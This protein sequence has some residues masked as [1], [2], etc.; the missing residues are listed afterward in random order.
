MGI[1]SIPILGAAVGVGFAIE[2]LVRGDPVGAGLEAVGSLGS[3]ITAIPATALQEAR[4]LY[5][6]FYG[7]YPEQDTA[8][9]K[10]Q[11]W[12]DLYEAVQDAIREELR[13]KATEKPEIDYSEIATDMMG[14]PIGV[15]PPLPSPPPP[16]QPVQRPSAPATEV[17]PTDK[18]LAAGTQAAPVQR[19]SAPAQL[20]P[21]APAP[22][23]AAAVSKPSTT[24]AGASSSG[25]FSSPGEFVRSMYPVATQASELI[26][27]KVPPVAILGQW[28]KESGNGKALSAPYNYAGI[29]AFGSFQKG[30]YVLTEERYTDAQLARAQAK[31]E[32]LAKVFSGPGDTMTKGGRTVALDQWYGKGAYEKA[33]AEGKSWVQVK[34]YFAKFNDFSDFAKGFASVLM[35]PRYAK[36]R[37]QTT[38]AGFGFE[39]AKAGYATASAENYS[40]GI[41]KF[42]ANEGANVGNASTAVAA[43]QRASSA[44]P[45]VTVIAAV[46]PSDTKKA[47]GLP[48]PRVDRPATVG[49]G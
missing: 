49:A 38:P 31:G 8:P 29:K 18:R 6:E 48:Q 5:I 40:A 16:P 34:S 20:P 43:A 33:K 41:A 28:A 32:T 3:A 19:P 25:V 7:V 42:A 30:D 24:A 35:S 21:P 27:G 37:E 22:S 11:R 23:P 13:K 10:E 17:N 9:D 46:A 44:Q 12:K 4:D 1:K 2:R 47:A 14:T 39:V 45:N 15:P 36:A 26:G